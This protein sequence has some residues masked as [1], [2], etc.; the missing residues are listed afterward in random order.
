MPIKAY[1]W[2]GRED[3]EFLKMGRF[4]KDLDEDEDGFDDEDDIDDVDDID[5]IDYDDIDGMDEIDGDNLDDSNLDDGYL[6]ESGK[7]S[8]TPRKSATHD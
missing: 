4:K 1:P 3:E 7:N 6:F 5:D 8:R 2:S